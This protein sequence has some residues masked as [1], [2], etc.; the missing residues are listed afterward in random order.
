VTVGCGSVAAP[1]V[2]A[3]S[4]AA[5]G[6]GP[7]SGTLAGEG[8]VAGGFAE[9]G[10]LNRYVARGGGTAAVGGS[11]VPSADG[12][13]GGA[14]GTGRTIEGSA[15]E[16]TLTGAEVVTEGARVVGVKTST[17]G[18]GSEREWP[19]K[20][21]S[22]T[23]PPAAAR[24]LAAASGLAHRNSAQRRWPLARR[25]NA[26]QGSGG[27]SSGTPAGESGISNC[28]ALAAGGGAAA[29]APIRSRR[30]RSSSIVRIWLLSGSS[31]TLYNELPDPLG[32][33]F[34]YFHGW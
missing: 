20:T 16:E 34:A 25:R 8:R 23:P 22:A 27:A 32:T 33:G 7:G 24:Q 31:T 28:A 5:P 1:G 6:G 19:V 14:M 10:E 29:S 13:G 4:A 2:P 15:V 21:S 17:V 26:S 18:G 3:R 11:V 30:E 12:L 9:V